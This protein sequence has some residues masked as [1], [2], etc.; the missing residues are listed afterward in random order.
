MGLA[1]AEKD[2]LLTS[3]LKEHASAAEEREGLIHQLNDLQN[4]H[5][6]A[7]K[8]ISEQKESILSLQQ[9]RDS[10]LKSS[11]DEIKAEQQRSLHLETQI[12]ELKQKLETN[13]AHNKVNDGITEVELEGVETKS[14]DF[15]F[16]PTGPSRRKSKKKSREAI[17]EK[18]SATCA[19]P[20][21]T[22]NPGINSVKFFIGVVAISILFGVFLGKRY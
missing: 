17:P 21:A 10:V 13:Q 5:N 14:R 20:P 8:V 19:E 18:T 9:E 7:Q 6:I 15:E 3:K 4:E 16:N 1:A 2:L 11:Q 22:E 12:E